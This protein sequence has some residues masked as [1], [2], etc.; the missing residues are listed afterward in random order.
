M[1]EPFDLVVSRDQHETIG[2]VTLVAGET[3]VVS[4]LFDPVYPRQVRLVGGG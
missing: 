1:V 3:V 4:W 2:V